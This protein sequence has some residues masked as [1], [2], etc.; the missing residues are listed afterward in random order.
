MKYDLNICR[1]KKLYEDVTE[2]WDEWKEKPI[3]SEI[4][5]GILGESTRHPEF[6]DIL[7][8]V[9]PKSYVTD[10]RIFGTPG[11]PRRIQFIDGTLESNSEVI[12][13]WSNSRYYMKAIKELRD[14]DIKVTI[15]IDLKEIDEEVFYKEI[16]KEN[17]NYLIIPQEFKTPEDLIY[18]KNNVQFIEYYKN[19]LLT[20]KKIII[21]KNYIN[22]KP[23]KVYD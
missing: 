10:G 9:K 17:E 23:I 4:R 6:L 13:L 19:I 20:N 16:W 14:S 12:L 18:E 5:L 21:T 2:T 15:G 8:R 3:N 11:D 1:L 22:L 7:K